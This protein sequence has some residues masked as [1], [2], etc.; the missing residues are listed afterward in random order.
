MFTGLPGRILESPAQARN[1]TRDDVSLSLP[2]GRFASVDQEVF[3]LENTGALKMPC[4]SRNTAKTTK[5]PEA[6]T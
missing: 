4:T 3:S 6:G 1:L 5:Y 2:R